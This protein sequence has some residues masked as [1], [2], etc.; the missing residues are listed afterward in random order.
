[1]GRFTNNNHELHYWERGEGPLLIIL[2]GATASSAHYSGELN[3]FS[4]NF[5]TV[6]LDF[7][8]TGDSERLAS[9]PDNWWK[10]CASDVAALIDHLGDEKAIILGSSMGGLVALLLAAIFPQKVLGVVCDSFSSKWSNLEDIVQK[11]SLKISDIIKQEKNIIKMIYRILA[12]PGRIMFYRIG[13]GLDSRQIVQADSDLLLRAARKGIKPLDGKL[14]KVTCPVLFIASRRDEV[15]LN[16]E[17]EQNQMA[18][19]VKNSQVYIGEKGSHPFMWTRKDEFRQVTE[20][21]IGKLIE[22]S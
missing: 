17:E 3:Y 14:A 8:G 4:E 16:V 5:R 2:P 13:H 15:L 12:I 6:A 7:W 11:R 21:F 10:E 19:Q 20:E 18:S 22:R 1:M 9:W